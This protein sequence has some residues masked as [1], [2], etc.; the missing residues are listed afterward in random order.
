MET[1]FSVAINPCKLA[2][3]HVYSAFIVNKNQTTI[4]HT[5]LKENIDK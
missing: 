3:T 4:V 1:K 2:I 5:T